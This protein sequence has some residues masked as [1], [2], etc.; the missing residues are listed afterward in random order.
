[1]GV[2]W[3]ISFISFTKRLGNNWFNHLE[4]NK[5]KMCRNIVCYMC[6][7]YCAVHFSH[8]ITLWDSSALLKKMRAIAR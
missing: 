4:K 8:T 2:R 7:N 1:M 5:N 6:Y 3:I